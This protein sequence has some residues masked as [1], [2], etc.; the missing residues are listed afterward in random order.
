MQGSPTM[1]I[2]GPCFIIDIISAETEERRKDMGE[3]ILIRIRPWKGKWAS[4]R[5]A[6]RANDMMESSVVPNH[7]ALYKEAKEFEAY[8]LQK[9]EKIISSG[10]K[11]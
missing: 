1:E 8:M 7:D 6:N 3:L 9:R 5:S 11:W 10:A 2:A 4:R